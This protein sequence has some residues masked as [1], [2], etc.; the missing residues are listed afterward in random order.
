MDKLFSQF[1]SQYPCQIIS[2]VLLFL[3]LVL[4]IRLVF[5]TSRTKKLNHLLA[6]QKETNMELSL[7]L[8]YEREKNSHLHAVQESTRKEMDHHFCLL[9]HK[10]VEEQSDLLSTRNKEKLD[11]LLT[12][13]KEQLNLFKTEIQQL[14]QDEVRDN[15]FL[16]SE[17]QQMQKLNS[18]ISEEAANL[19]KALKG[20]KKVQGNWGEMILE[21]LLEHCG[22]REGHEYKTQ[23]GFRND[24][25][26]LYKP[27]VIVYLPGNRNIIIDS[28][29]SL[30]SWERFINSPEK[31]AQIKNMKEHV[32]AL[33]SHIN[34]LSGKDYSNLE[35]INSLDFVLMF[36]P[37]EEAYN[38]ALQASPDL[39]EQALRQNI[40]PVTPSSLLTTL[41]TIENLWQYQKREQNSSQILKRASALYDKFRLFTEDMEKLGI[42]LDSCQSVYETAVTRLTRG[43][44]NLVSQV[45]KLTEYGIRTK[46]TLPTDILHRTDLEK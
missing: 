40:I 26:R 37:I 3:V 42:Q 39:F 24:E 15:S 5:L 16:R 10:I 32:Q 7:L 1:F 9:A 21:R 22:L 29:V 35:G 20:D 41:R 44:G 12:P 11:R 13:F 31:T 2:S 8:S 14:H 28:K 30:I 23:T 46:K 4:L 27:D 6:G 38:Q 19:A 45:Q 18:R 17:L 25:K 33:K 43:K 36:I 34:G